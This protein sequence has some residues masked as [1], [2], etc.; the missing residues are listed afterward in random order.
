MIV[1]K[2]YAFLIKY[3]RI[4]HLFILILSSYVLYKA[5]RLFIFFSEYSNTRQL[6][7]TGNSQVYIPILIFIFSFLIIVFSIII[8]ILLKEKDKPKLFY[9]IMII[10]YFALII[11]LF[12]SKTVITEIE[13]NGI[14]P[15]DAR[16]IRDISLIFFL[17]QIPISSFILIRTLGFDIKRFHFGEDIQSLEIDVSD[18]EE[19]EIITG[20]DTDKLLRKKEEMKE[21]LKAF[22]YENKAVLIIISIL[23]F[24]VLPATFVIRN[25]VENKMYIEKENIILSDLNIKISSSYITK[26][27]YDGKTLLTSKNSY[28]IVKFNLSNTKDKEE[29]ININN[30][31]L[32]IDDKVYSTNIT[33][34]DNFIDLGKGYYN[35][36]IKNGESKD[37]IVVFV[38][39]DSYLNK[40]MVLRYKDSVTYKNSEAIASYKKVLISPKSLN[41]IK[42]EEETLLNHE[43][44]FEDSLLEDTKLTINSYMIK[45]KFTYK[46]NNIDKYVVNSNG[47]VLRI[48]YKFNINENITFISNFSDFINM[49]ATLIYEQNGNEI[50]GK[51][52]NITPKN[53]VDNSIFLSVDENIK[54]ATSIKIILNVRNI[55]YIYTLK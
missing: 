28:V 5:N 10:I 36:E 33:Y 23:L 25:K 37:Y 45:D 51:T 32:L 2:P 43:L 27:N 7:S 39:D 4:I 3:F 26:Y 53:Y 6:L 42:E 35:Q 30:F 22:Y 31:K 24:V 48:D 46:Y 47:L 9:L 52:I 55:K 44:L 18:S 38:I 40:E 50:K 14:S 8:F 49:Y 17:I 11:F 34:Y 19:V 29:G 16:I 12:I 54:D 15:K 21:E 1:R 20:I 41:K 13:L